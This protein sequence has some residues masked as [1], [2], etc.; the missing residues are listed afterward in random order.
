[1]RG[2]RQ[3]ATTSER[4]KALELAEALKAREMTAR[5][6]I[7]RLES[8]D[9]AEG[10][11]EA[12]RGGGGAGR[13]GGSR[14]EG[15]GAANQLLSVSAQAEETAYY[16]TLQFLSFSEGGGRES[17]GTCPALRHYCMRP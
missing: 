4:V 1:M 12:L 15:G 17:P 16:E 2:I 13:G 9:A 8:G 6:A 3:E 7:V 14:S 11:W 5:A 10:M